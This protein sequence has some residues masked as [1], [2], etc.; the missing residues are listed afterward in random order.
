MVN[1]INEVDNMKKMMAGS[2]IAMAAGAGM[3]AYALNSKQTKKNAKKLVNNAMS[4]ANDKIN[5]MK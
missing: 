5:A 2:L 4:L 3:M 1:N